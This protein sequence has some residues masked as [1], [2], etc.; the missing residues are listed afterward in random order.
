MTD[1]SSPGL[2]MRA[3]WR[4]FSRASHDYDRAALLQHEVREEL[5]SR[6][7][8]VRATPAVIVDVGCGTGRGTRALEQRFPRSRVIALDAA[9]GMLLAA[10]ARQRWWRRFPRLRADAAALPFAD[11]SVDLLFSNLMLQWCPDPHVVFTEFHRVLRPGG[12]LHFTTFGPDTLRELRRAFA[13]VDEHTHV[14]A[15]ADMHELGD[16]LIRVGFAEPV[17]DVDRHVH[18]Y[19]DTR[20]LMRDLKRIGAHNVTTHRPRGL[21]GRHRWTAMQQAYERERRDGRLP[22]TY[23]VVYGH[24]WRVAT[25]QHREPAGDHVVPVRAIG[26]RRREGP[27]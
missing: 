2:D 5:L 26:R 14:N 22:A 11:Q 27:P 8:V 1:H 18:T 7:D 24:A 19:A 12:L 15:F 4:S 21:T 20:G 3:A 13:S 23:E 6:L 9:H 16:G 25:P 17:M 10:R